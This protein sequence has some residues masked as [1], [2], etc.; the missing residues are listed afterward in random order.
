[1]RSVITDLPIK[2]ITSPPRNH[3]VGYYDVCPWDSENKFLFGLAVDFVNRSIT[4]NDRAVIG[5]IDPS[6]EFVFKRICETSAWNWQQGAR[7]HW[8]P[9][10]KK[11]IF[12]DRNS[13][14]FFSRIV[15]VKNFEERTLSYPIYSL[16][17]DG[18][19]ALCINFSRLNHYR[20]GYGY[21]DVS[22]RLNDQPC[23]RDDGIFLMNLE[24]RDIKLLLSYDE[25]AK[26]QPLAYMQN[27]KHWVNHIMFSPDDAHFSFIHRWK[28][29]NR[30]G[31]RLVTVNIE[32]DRIHVF[33]EHGMV[34]HYSW[35][36]NSSLI[37]WL[38]YSSVRNSS[39]WYS[40]INNPVISNILAL[41]MKVNFFSDIQQTMLGDRFYYLMDEKTMESATQIPTCLLSRDGHCSFSPN[42]KWLL[43]DTYPDKNRYQNLFL[44]HV[45]KKI[46]YLLG[47]FYSPNW[48]RGP[49]RCDLHSR[50]DRNGNMVCIDSAHYG[51][52][53][54]YLLDLKKIIKS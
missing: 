41:N 51:N 46:V 16:S 37:A 3:F 54:I 35:K 40:I 10:T 22:D 53:Q 7:V 25:L 2:S 42:K 45:E 52:R 49:M 5:V 27:A 1:M 34:S 19:K 4:H 9:S 15:D 11:L 14:G 50:W 12:N 20:K 23:P 33:N 39:L 26:Y 24:S 18:R 29:F 32:G 30:V 43:V 28:Y 13:K 6:N 48:S 8:I 47:K 21:P 44:F 31:S 17:S 36:D 38:R